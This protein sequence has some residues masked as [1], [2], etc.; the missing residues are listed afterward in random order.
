MKSHA[1]APGS[2]RYFVVVDGLICYPCTS[3]DNA[4]EVAVIAVRRFG[5][6]N[7]STGVATR[8]LKGRAS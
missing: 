6:D 2:L 3:R 1:A 5:C 7:V 8:A 4:I